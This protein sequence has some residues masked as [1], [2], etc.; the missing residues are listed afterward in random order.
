MSYMTKILTDFEKKENRVSTELDIKKGK[1]KGW[2]WQCMGKK[3]TGGKVR[4]F[5]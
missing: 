3:L 4:N 2:P 1:E 5:A